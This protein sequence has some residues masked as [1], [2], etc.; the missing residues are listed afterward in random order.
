MS[1]PKLA[2][3]GGP[4]TVRGMFP[5]PWSRV[6]KAVA[7]TGDVL[8]MI[9]RI[10]RGRTTIGDGSKI[11]G[12]FEKAFADL[13]GSNHALAMNNGTATLHS[14]YVA[15]GVGPGDE[16]IVPA[17]T[18]H[19]SATP[20]LQCNA[21]P[22]FCDI[23]PDTF[24]ADP[25]DIERRITDRTKAIC[26]VHVWGAPAEMDR[27]C[28]IAD[29]HNIAVIEDCSHAHGA[30]Y[31]GKS[32]GTWGAVGCFSLNG[33]KAVDA[34]EGGV[35]VTD[36]PQLFDRMLLLGHF[37]RVAKG[38]A[39][40]SFNIGDMS[41]GLKYRP[42]QCAMHLAMGSLKRLS[43]LNKRCERAWNWLCDELRDVPGIRPQ[44]TLPG[45]QRGGYLEFV[46]AYDGA[47]LGGPSREDFAKA[48]RKEGAPLRA[49]RYAQVN[50]TYGMLHKAP[51]FT[52]LYRPGLGGGCFDP[53]RDWADTI[54]TATLPVC[55][56]LAT[57]LV[58]LPR[59]DGASK[60][61]VRGCGKAIKKVL[62]GM[63]VTGSIKTADRQNLEKTSAA[64]TESEVHA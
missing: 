8:K 9:P 33:K 22:V 56:R 63:G 40:E 18:W 7:V 13:T 34:G 42:H 44:R 26:V 16:V 11:V 41:L 47:E 45:G 53:T 55:E 36:D 58:S 25:D 15:V 64:K 37:G 23:D 1:Q 60:G 54:H 43:G 3:K 27:I 39:A 35:A 2:I 10:A 5:T 52:E 12:K 57:G 20:I 17:Y 61:Y 59:L 19:A 50:Y 49:D 48:V 4:K 46:M 24:T 6:F 51:L 30:V 28:E 31:K 21:T 14:A 38:Q 62:I 29:R 32:V